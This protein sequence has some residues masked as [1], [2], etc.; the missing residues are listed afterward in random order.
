[1]SSTLSEQPLLS[2]SS[3]PI[4]GVGG[5]VGSEVSSNLAL[6]TGCEIGRDGWGTMLF[7]GGRGD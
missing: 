1:M 4:D 2:A 7:G 6:L 5:I 3:L